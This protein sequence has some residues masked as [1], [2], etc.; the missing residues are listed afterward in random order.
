MKAF[1]EKNPVKADFSKSSYGFH[2]DVIV[3]KENSLPKDFDQM[4]V[5]KENILAY[6]EHTGHCHKLFGENIDLR[7]CP[8]TKTKYLRLVD[9]V[10]LKHQEHAP[11]VLPPGTY[12][13]G[14]QKEY[15]HFEEITREVAD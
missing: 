3:Y 7:E 10:T 5:I 11:V 6:G 15:D 4:K 12:R 14:I 9:E 8:K 1:N 13:I 2:G